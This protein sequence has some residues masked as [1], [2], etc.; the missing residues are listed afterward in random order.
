L[1][2]A[3]E[4]LLLHEKERRVERMRI[5]GRESARGRPRPT[6]SGKNHVE[7]GIGKNNGKFKRRPSQMRRI[8]GVCRGKFQPGCIETSHLRCECIR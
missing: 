1:L 6:P 8:E 3:D 7:S 2:N 5:P 4:R